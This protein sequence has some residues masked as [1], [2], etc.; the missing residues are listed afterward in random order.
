MKSSNRTRYLILGLLNESPLSGYEIKKIVDMRFSYFWS[1]SYGQ[2]YP[3]LNR[4]CNEGLIKKVID[5]DDSAPRNRCKY[6]ITTKGGQALKEW[7]LSPV[8]KEMIRYELLL[9]LYF[10]NQ[11]SADA[12]IAHI[13]EF[14][15]SHKQQQ[16]MFALFQKDLEA[17]MDLHDNHPEIL[18][19]LLFGQKV[20]AAYDEWCNEVLVLLN[21]RKEVEHNDTNK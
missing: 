1:E 16:E 12:M 11:E 6:E 7:L 2:I 17:H 21:K 3:E 9:K 8:E 13:E 20:W 4:M 15:R 18:M 5:E 10:S 19:V 14:Q